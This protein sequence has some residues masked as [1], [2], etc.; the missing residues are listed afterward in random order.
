MSI[1]VDPEKCIACG[2]CQTISPIFDYDEDG[3][4]LLAEPDPF[5]D[6]AC[7]RASK[8]CPTRAIL[9]NKD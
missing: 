5:I 1:R 6:S 2:L 4:V 3:Y 9:I 7:I 8:S